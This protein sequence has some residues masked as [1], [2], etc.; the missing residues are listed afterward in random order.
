[1]KRVLGVL[2]LAA[3]AEKSATTPPPPTSSCGT[4]V[5]LAQ[6][7][8]LPEVA[9]PGIGIDITRTGGAAGAATVTLQTSDGSAVAGVDYAATST[10]VEF[11]DG[12]TGSRRID[13]PVFDDSGKEDDEDFT[14]TLIAT[15]GD[16]STTSVRI[17]DNDLPG[18]P[19]PETYSV[20]GTVV[21]LVGQG[22]VLRNSG[23]EITVSGTTFAFTAKWLPGIPYLVEVEEQPLNPLQICRV[24]DGQ[25]TIAGDVSNVLVTCE[26]PAAGG[27]LDDAFGTEGV[28]TSGDIGTPTAVAVAPLGMIVVA[29][30][31]T[32][33]SNFDFLLARYDTDGTFLGT[34]LAPFTSDK[35]D[36]AHAVAVQSDGKIVMVGH[37]AI[38]FDD[39][40]FAIA[41][42]GSDGVLDT[43]FDG[44]G[45]VTTDF[46]S[47]Y[48]SA[49]AVAIQDDGKIV[50]A[51]H[52]RITSGDNDFAVARYL[53]TGALDTSFGNGTGKATVNLSGNGDL[54]SH[55]VVLSSGRILV[56]GRSASSGGAIADLGIACFE[57]NGTACSAFGTAG[58]IVDDLGGDEIVRGVA[59][60]A[61]D[62]LL[63]LTNGTESLRTT[64]VVTRFTADGVQDTAFG[65]IEQ[66]ASTDGNDFGVGIGLLAADG[67][68]AVGN[69]NQ[70]GDLDM[71]L[72]PSGETP[73]LVDVRG[74]NDVPTAMAVDGSG[75]VVVV[76]ETTGGLFVA[77]LVL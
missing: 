25:G 46:S 21:G 65:T 33:T 57:T 39:Y 28:V 52:A 73:S 44:D 45:L 55:V 42:F 56:I 38:S 47:Q 10:V 22:L 9:Q 32:N 50:V 24:T 11:A 71:S 40:D 30:Y 68:V 70:G 41:R 61:S 58:F 13:I 1:M 19:A 72:H 59:R 17:I 60:Q 2:I 74:L 35:N 77:R 31:A 7:L 36:E 14:V 3:C 12:E 48:D 27:P 69:A 4:F 26:T 62:H 64:Q 16:S 54:A 34:T 20:S 66:S 51:G 6:E 63:I 49:N 29:G 76:G 8:A 53:S 67:Y 23:E 75:R 37:S 43:S 18:T 15:C 5:F